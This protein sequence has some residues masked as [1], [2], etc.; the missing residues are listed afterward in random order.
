MT[1]RYAHIKIVSLVDVP[2]HWQ[3]F[4]EDY[5]ISDGFHIWYDVWCSQKLEERDNLLRVIR[6]RHEVVRMH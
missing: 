6:E 5:E 2:T 4:D 3:I 1:G